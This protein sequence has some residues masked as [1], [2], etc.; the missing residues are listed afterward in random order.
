[1]SFRPDHGR[2]MFWA[3]LW[4]AVLVAF[5]YACSLLIPVYVNNYQLQDAMKNEARY[6]VVEHKNQSQIQDDVYRTAKGLGIPA[7]LEAIDVEPIEGGYRITVNYTIPLRIF[8]R[9]FDLRF[10]TTADSN[11]I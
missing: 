1:M 10:H 9:S 7:S 2:G 6:A 4:L 5:G 11:S 3:L 8:R